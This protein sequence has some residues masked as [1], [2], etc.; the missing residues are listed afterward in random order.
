MNLETLAHAAATYQR[1]PRELAA[2]VHVAQAEAAEKAGERIPSGPTPALILN[3]LKYFHVLDIEAGVDW[4]R[5][6][7]AEKAAE[8]SDE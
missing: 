1:H 6:R 2:G 8:A 4:L 7:D 3:G 5:R